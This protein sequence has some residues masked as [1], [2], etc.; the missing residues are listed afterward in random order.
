M[1]EEL[2]KLEDLKFE[3]N[4]ARVTKQSEEI[5]KLSKLKYEGQLKKVLKLQKE[6]DEEL[7][8]KA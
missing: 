8:I 3:Y 7:H 5:I 4:L 6:Q 2:N 1:E